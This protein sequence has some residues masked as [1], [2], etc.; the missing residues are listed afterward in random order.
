MSNAA[1]QPVSNSLGLTQA[2]EESLS[3]RAFTKV[4]FTGVGLCYAG[5]IGYPI[6]KYLA[7][8]IQKS[9]EAAKVS[10]VRACQR[11]R[12]LRPAQLFFSSLVQSP[13]F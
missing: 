8:P 7:S 11:R 10:E 9:M 4:L 1:E 6:Y 2:Q 13:A 5:A 12:N 3:R